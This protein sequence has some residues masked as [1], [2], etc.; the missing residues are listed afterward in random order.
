MASRDSVA[1]TLEPFDHNLLINGMNEFRNLL[2]RTGRPTDDV[3]DLL[4]R[5][6]DAKP[7][8]SRRKEF[9]RER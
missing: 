4:L 3:D 1:I 8:R 7:R 6:I 2:I 9:S 5:L